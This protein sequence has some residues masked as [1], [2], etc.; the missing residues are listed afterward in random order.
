VLFLIVIAGLLFTR[1]LLITG[2]VTDLS[3]FVQDSN[4]SPFW[5]M[6]AIVVVYL[7]LGCFIDTVSMMVMTIPFV[8]PLIKTAGFDPVWFGV[9]MIKLVEIACITPPVGLNL[10]AV[11]SAVRGKVSATQLFAGVT[12]FVLI[13][14]C[15]L[16][17]LLAYPQIAL[18]LPSLMAK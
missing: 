4:L 11:L 6:A 8:Y 17:L 13:E 9:I 14:I 15:S 1:M 16:G 18:W 10:Y 12:P 2:L 3:T 5:L 7:I